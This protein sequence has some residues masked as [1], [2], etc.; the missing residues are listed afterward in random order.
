MPPWDV[1]KVKA[2]LPNVKVK[3]GNQIH[4]GRV[5]GR[6]NKFATVSVTNLGT[7]HAKSRV[8]ADFQ[9]AWPTIVHALNNDRPLIV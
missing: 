7:L 6:L 3:I 2:E 9:V 5:S 4:T 8:F 1:E